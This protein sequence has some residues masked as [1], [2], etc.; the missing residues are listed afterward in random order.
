MNRLRIMLIAAALMT[1]G[2][3]LASAQVYEHGGKS[4]QT[5]DRDRDRDDKRGYD[6]DDRYRSFD[7]DRDKRDRDDR[8]KDRDDYRKYERR[9]N[10]RDRR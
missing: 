9:D 1:G 4:Y 7:R 5:G 2:S 10:D 3:A 6:R 8:K